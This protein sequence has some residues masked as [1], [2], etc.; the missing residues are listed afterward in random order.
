[1]NKLWVWL[2]LVLGLVTASSVGAVALLAHQYVNQDFRSFLVVSQVQEIGLDTDLAAYWGHTGSWA[3]VDAVIRGPQRPNPPGVPPGAPP[4]G[5]DI[6]RLRL[7]DAA[8][9]VVYPPAGQAPPPAPPPPA[10]P[11]RPPALLPPAPPSEVPVPIE[12]QGRTVG[13]LWVR[14]L[15]ADPL[16]RPAQAF[17]GE[18]NQVLLQAGLL[19]GGGGLLVGVG[20]AIWLAAP[21][22]RMERATRQI[23]AG[24]LE[25]QVPTRGVAEMARLAR[26]FNEMAASLRRSEQLRR[27]MV[28][29][30]AHELRTPLSVLQGNLQALLDGVYPLAPAEIA[31]LYDETRLLNRLVT[32]LHELAQ[33]E[34]GQL[35]LQCQA[36]VVEPLVQGVV[37]LFG[38]PARTGGVTLAVHAA[39]ALPAVW[40]DPARVRQVL[41]N[42]VGNAVRY[43]PAGGAI[44]ITLAA[45]PGPPGPARPARLPA[46]PM[47]R[48]EVA[49]TGPGLSADEAGQVFGRFWR[50]DQAR[51]RETGG[52]GLGLAIA[53]QLVEA[54]GGQIGVTS[55]VGQGSR[56]WF[57]LPPV[58]A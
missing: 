17:L 39:P 13:T 14:T 21:L 47:V 55:A 6:G 51:A 22:A 30:I 31:T 16:A 23:A 2:S 57:T 11:G 46:A 7:T 28:S 44:T 20:L 19:V 58:R 9:Q 36:V 18:M 34:A 56:F 43:T 54:Q 3:G 4:R 24:Q 33:A 1:M 5:L 29:D 48:I 38:E 41:T 37:A 49:D 10:G 15:P 8:G 42:L 53:R 27:S 12:W 25:Q 52:A 32:D 35:R 26:A 40:A 45:A 50:A